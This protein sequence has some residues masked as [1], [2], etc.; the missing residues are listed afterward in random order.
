MSSYFK[1]AIAFVM[2]IMSFW[3]LTSCDYLDDMKYRHVIIDYETLDIYYDNERYV[4]LGNFDEKS[5]VTPLFLNHTRMNITKEGVPVL[6]SEFYKEYYTCR[7]DEERGLFQLGNSDDYYCH[8][9]RLDDYKEK[10]ENA[11]F[12]RYIVN[13]RVYNEKNRK[14][15]NEVI[16]LTDVDISALNEVLSTGATVEN[17]VYFDSS[18]LLKIRKCD[19]DYMVLSSE[20]IALYSSGEDYYIT[21]I[22][23][24]KGTNLTLKA[25]DDNKELLNRLRL[26]MNNYRDELRYELVVSTSY[27]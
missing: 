12:D 25:P 21:V 22:D 9:D 15:E 24:Y 6:L 16:E 23:G 7:Y 5:R 14:N 4:V 1:K 11:V 8:E 27:T 17:S 3:S 20:E 10:I 2:I 18:L 19:K 26:I 13:R